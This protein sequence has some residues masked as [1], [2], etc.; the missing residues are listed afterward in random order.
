M[1]LCE[2]ACARA[3]NWQQVYILLHCWEQAYPIPWSCTM[4]RVFFLQYIHLPLNCTHSDNRWLFVY[5]L[6]IYHLLPLSKDCLEGLGSIEKLKEQ[7]YSSWESSII[8]FNLE[9]STSPAL[10][11][12]IVEHGP[13][14]ISYTFSP[15]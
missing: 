5:N 8:D 4:V 1:G 12:Y 13:N 10:Y 15:R 6:S 9:P 3:S 11:N 7:I 14:H 2:A